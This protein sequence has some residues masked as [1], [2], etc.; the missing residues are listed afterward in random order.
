[1][2][3]SNTIFNRL[4]TIRAGATA[5]FDRRPFTKVMVI[6]SGI[7]VGL[8]SAVEYAGRRKKEPKAVRVFPTPYRTSTATAKARTDDIDRLERV[9]DADRSLAVVF[10]PPLSGKTDLARQYAERF[11]EKNGGSRKFLKIFSS[12]FKRR[13]CH[14][15]TL[16]ANNRLNL[17][18]SLRAMAQRLGVADVAK[19]GDPTSWLEAIVEDGFSDSDW[20]MIFDH[21]SADVLEWDEVRKWLRS[22][23]EGQGQKLL[24]L[25]AE[26]TPTDV[27][28]N[29]IG[30]GS[31][32]WTVDDIFESI[33][34]LAAK[35]AANERAFT[36][37]SAVVGD[38]PL[39]PV[40]LLQRAMYD[41]V[42]HLLPLPIVGSVGE[43]ALVATETRGP[44]SNLKNKLKTIKQDLND[45]FTV[46]QMKFGFQK[47][48]KK[49]QQQS[50][51]PT[52]AAVAE[53]CSAEF[54]RQ[55]PF[56][57]RLQFGGGGMAAIHVSRP[58]QEALSRFLCQVVIPKR[59]QERLE[60]QR[61]S[62]KRSYV[63][64]FRSFD[65]EQQFLENRKEIPASCI[66]QG[67]VVFHGVPFQPY[68][69]AHLEDIQRDAARV[70]LE[71]AAAQE[72][73]IGIFTRGLLLPLMALRQSDSRQLRVKML[74]AEAATLMD[75][76]GDTQRAKADLEAA[77][78]LAKAESDKK[79]YAR[80]LSDL[81][82]VYF[83]EKDVKKSEERLQQ[84][85]QIYE[86]FKAPRLFGGLQ[87]SEQVEVSLG[88]GR[89]LSRL[90]A[91]YGAM[92][93][94]VRG[95]ECCEQVFLLFQYLPPDEAGTYS[96]VSELASSLVDLGEAYLSEGKYDY[97]KKVLELGLTINQNV[98]GEKHTEV[99]RTMTS[100][101]VV[102]WMLGDVKIGEKMREEAE[103]IKRSALII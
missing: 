15:V 36:F 54:L 32:F 67:R 33:C 76:F 11:V 48:N 42:N 18:L 16:E 7:V 95:R 47:D 41:G 14:V 93:D 97:A 56:M 82:V 46:A 57:Q 81:G 85:I 62:H 74:V 83:H 94:S 43:K 99:G 30:D 68:E 24:V 64:W 98:R 52:P 61:S 103:K 51:A 44:V 86:S 100:L 19:G 92:G 6:A 65:D 80:V 8:A 4:R 73:Q 2:F 101:G 39:V 40:S 37:L 102:H 71:E 21:V 78:S 70:I 90:G 5:Y 38:A 17:I 10:G 34:T 79:L 9:F 26:T 3:R 53:S 22:K 75:V 96:H 28:K 87:R 29:S 63:S 12:P 27:A 31:P 91:V 58:V 77:C 89:A 13:R 1:M 23:V 50:S 59:E 45:I 25:D 60:K 72:G 55:C 35:D 20:L 88:L 69:V 84:A 49:A 66:S